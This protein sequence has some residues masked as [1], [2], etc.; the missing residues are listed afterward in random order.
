MTLQDRCLTLAD[1]LADEINGNLCYVPDEEIESCLAD[2][3]PDNLNETAE[4]LA[5][6]AS[7]FN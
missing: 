2:L 5:Q 4:Q 6:L 3:T 7:W 1:V